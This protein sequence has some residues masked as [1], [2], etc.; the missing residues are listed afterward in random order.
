[1]FDD[2]D[3]WVSS[4]SQLPRKL[5]KNISNFR[6]YGYASISLHASD[7]CCNAFVAELARHRGVEN[8]EGF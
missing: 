6:G 2:D 8:T 5:K 4:V 1:M 3:E 7:Y